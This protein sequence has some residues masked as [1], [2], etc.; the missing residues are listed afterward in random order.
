MKTRTPLLLLTSLALALSACGELTAL[1]ITLVTDPN[2]NDE[3]SL[4]SALDRVRL[5]V[6]SPGGLYPA[7]TDL[8]DGDLQIKDV[9]GDGDAEL[10]ATVT[11]N[12]LGRLPVVRLEQGGLKLVPLEIRVDGL[13]AGGAAIAAG[14][15]QGIDFT[16]G[17]AAAI[18]VPFNL[19]PAYRPPRVTQV[20]PPNNSDLVK[21]STVSSALVIFSKPMNMSSLSR[22][23]VFRVLAV[24]GGT[25]TEVPVKSITGGELY[26]GG[27][28][29][30]EYLFKKLLSSPGT[31]EVRISAGALDTSG[32]ALDQ[33]PLQAGNQAFSSRFTVVTSMIAPACAPKCETAWCG[34]G[35]T[36]C[37]DGLTCHE[38]SGTCKPA[39]C[40]KACPK[41]MVCDPGL[42]AC[43][44]DCRVHGTH[45]GCAKDAPRCLGTGLGGK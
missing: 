28:S 27:P 7:G 44:D 12:G 5:V 42:G 25:R 8:T 17:E 38:A 10:L 24:A 15:V 19:K 39:G 35:G 33:V 43:V 11:V 32:R 21:I 9:D 3:A 37:P 14:G 34:N 26:Q 36:K 40:P 1:D 22:A 4:V 31:F 20:F 45:G 23:G 16:E 13:A 29:K 6:D 30:A 41:L 18:K 2:V